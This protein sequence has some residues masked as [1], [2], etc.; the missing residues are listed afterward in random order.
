METSA[1][2]HWSLRPAVAEHHDVAERR[3]VGLATAGPNKPASVRWLGFI[4]KI[5]DGLRSLR[6]ADG[7]DTG[8]PLTGVH[9]QGEVRRERIAEMLA[10][11]FHRG[12]GGMERA[13]LT[14]VAV[15]SART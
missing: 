9:R 5:G 10:C 11:R 6:T 12:I 7:H 15:R 14:R 8:L 1:R 2:H 3:I 13:E 4:P